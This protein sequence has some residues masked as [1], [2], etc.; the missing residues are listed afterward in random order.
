MADLTVV[1]RLSMREARG[2]FAL[3]ELGLK[4]SLLV[5]EREHD[6]RAATRGVGKLTQAIEV[7]T[8]PRVRRGLVEPGIEYSL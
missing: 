5:D 8:T 3:A 2:L 4:V 6:H 7:A 1:V